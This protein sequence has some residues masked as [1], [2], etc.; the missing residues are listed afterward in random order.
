MGAVVP[1]EAGREGGELDGCGEHPERHAALA[2]RLH[3]RDDGRRVG[4]VRLRQD[5]RHGEKEG[6]LEGHFLHR[7]RGSRLRA[8]PLGRAREGRADLAV[9]GEVLHRDA[10]ALFVAL[11]EGMPF[12]HEDPAAGLVELRHVEVLRDVRDRVER[13][14][15][16]VVAQAVEDV[17]PDLFDDELRLRDLFVEGLEAFRQKRG[18]PVVGGE[19]PH[20]ALGLGEFEDVPVQEHLHR[21]EHLLHVP[22]DLTHA[23][24]REHGEP[25]AHEELVFEEF[26]QLREPA[27]CGAH[28]QVMP[29]RREREA[30]R[31]R[32]RHEKLEFFQG[33]VADLVLVHRDGRRGWENGAGSR[34]RSLTTDGPQR[35]AA[36]RV[37]SIQLS[38]CGPRRTSPCSRRSARR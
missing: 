36:I 18:D 13:E 22:F 11:D 19:D 4:E 8:R 29:L 25:R 7:R 1:D 37:L 10:A 3:E 31:F 2:H 16:G 28:A 34:R 15:G 9:G 33:E 24:C 12:A 32:E 23:L 26:T 30:V 35:F 38:G 6:H 21:A 27:G 17:G 20:G 5:H 14:V